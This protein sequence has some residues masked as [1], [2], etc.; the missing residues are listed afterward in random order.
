MIQLFYPTSVR[1]GT[2]AAYLPPKTAALTAATLH[3]PRQ[4]VAS[5]VTHALSAPP[6]APGAHPLVLFSPGLTEL[7]TDDAGL[8]TDLASHGYVVV[9][10]DHP[11][12][13]A[14]VEFPGGEV[15]R[16]SFT[17][18]PDPRTSTLL[19]AEAVQARVRDVAAVVRALPGIDQHGLL[20]GRLDLHRIGMFG[21]SIGGAT[22]DEAMHAISQIRAGV[23]LDG[24]LYGSSL[25]KPLD[26]PFLF[27]ARDGHNTDTDQS[28]RQ[29][30]SMLH[31]WRREFHLIGAGHGDFTDLAGL[32]AQFAPGYEDPTGYYG[33]IAPA[34]ATTT[35][36]QVLT[37]FFDRFLRG[38]RAADRLLENPARANHDIVRL[39]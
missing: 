17:D 11:H 6:A 19:R 37:A 1:R 33:P 22:A 14:V 7:R 8:D 15:L 3:M 2:P 29:G 18:S 16:G 36:R 30:W 35:I 25:R 34:R 27:L 39:K 23:N 26:R 24:S 38:D 9:A 28:W 32:F 4:I 13:S 10:I 21:F 5:I 20:R 31:G 12:E